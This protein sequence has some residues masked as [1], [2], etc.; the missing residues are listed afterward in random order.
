MFF[1]LSL[2]HYQGIPIRRAAAMQ[3][4]RLLLLELRQAY[5]GYSTFGDVDKVL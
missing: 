4:G 1:F 3:E 5:L 2:G